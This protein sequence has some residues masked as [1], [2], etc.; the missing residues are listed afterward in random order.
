MVLWLLKGSLT[1]W[2]RDISC[3]IR[4]H[5]WIMLL[6]RKWAKRTMTK[7]TGAVACREDWGFYLQWKQ[8]DL[9]CNATR[10]PWLSSFSRPNKTR[11]CPS[12]TACG[13]SCSQV[14]ERVEKVFGNEDEP[15]M[16]ECDASEYT[17][18]AV[19]NQGGRP[20][21]FMSRTLSPSECRYSSIEKEATSIRSG[22]KMGA[23]SAWS[24]LHFDYRPK[25]CCV[26]V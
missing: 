10:P 9:F 19:L 16:V 21:A 18:G 8:I 4:S 11:P 7:F 26:Y 23:L 2:L 5:T 15:F 22:S 14:S 24:N 6:W 17:I 13:L 20:V 1:T 12:S 25:I 3:K